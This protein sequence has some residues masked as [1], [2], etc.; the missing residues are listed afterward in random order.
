MLGGESWSDIKRGQSLN[1]V[2]IAAGL[3]ALAW[4]I[5]TDLNSGSAA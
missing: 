1:A 5:V 3:S 4:F 2:A